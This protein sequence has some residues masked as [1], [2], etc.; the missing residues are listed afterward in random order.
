MVDLA[1]SVPRAA[2]HRWTARPNV[3]W[4]SCSPS[5]GASLGLAQKVVLNCGAKDL[6]T[7]RHRA[8]VTFRTD[9]GFNRTV[10]VAL[11][12]CRKPF[13]RLIEV[14]AGL[15]A[16]GIAKV[17]DLSVS[18]GFYVHMPIPP[19]GP[20][21]KPG[22]TQPGTATSQVPAD[23]PYYVLGR[24]QVPEPTGIHDS[25]FA[26]IDGGPAAMWDVH[27]GPQSWPW[28]MLNERGERTRRR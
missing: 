10:T 20:E 4:L 1:L 12:V 3:N 15:V 5:S 8:A 26:S 17:A 25:S 9:L 21:G 6:E 19:A 22:R 7:R 13:V 2:G 24:C 27:A 23:G 11:K 18:D 14:E 28:D 16:G